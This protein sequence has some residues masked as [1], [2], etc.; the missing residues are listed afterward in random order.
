[1]SGEARYLWG[2]TKMDFIS[3][4]PRSAPP[5]RKGR[6]YMDTN[7]GFSFCADGTSFLQISDV[8]HN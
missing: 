1:M 3:L 8:L 2:D 7:L 6:L 5:A 4:K